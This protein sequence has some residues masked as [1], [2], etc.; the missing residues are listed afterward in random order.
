MDDEGE[1]GLA[2]DRAKAINRAESAWPNPATNQANRRT[3]P[4]PAVQLVAALQGRM[5]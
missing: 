2:S 1:R 3:V 4:D 5:Q